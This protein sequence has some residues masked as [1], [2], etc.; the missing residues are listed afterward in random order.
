MKLFI[1]SLVGAIII[2][3]F[4]FLSW[5]VLN[6]HYPAQQYTPKQDSILSY[7]ST[8]FDSSG[9]YILPTIPKG[10]SSDD[11]KALAEKS[12]GKPWAQIA[13]HKSLNTS[14]GVN[15]IKNLVTNFFMVLLFCWIIAGYTANSFGKTFLASIF[16][17]LIVF[18]HG[19]YTV[20][21]WYETFDLGAHFADYVISWGLTGIWLGWWLNRRKA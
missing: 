17:G 13:Y 19:A 6:L 8:Q 14:M 7:L 16:T 2:F 21:I 11:M 12:T 5:G 4:Q 18:L 3:V 9:G 1:G 20:H 15:M 10:A